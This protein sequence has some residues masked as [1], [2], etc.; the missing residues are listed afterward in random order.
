MTDPP[1]SH[2]PT[3]AL[4]PR[5]LRRGLEIFAVISIAGGAGA[6]LYGNNFHAF[7]TAL[8]GLHWWWLI[9]GLGLASLDWFGA[10][11]RL[12]VVGRHV[13]PGVRWLG[14]V[15]SMVMTAWGAS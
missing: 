7:I 10:G 4:T 2:A 1:D 15:I 12:W 5:L 11:T 8:L 6:L 9:V 3:L 14:I 13:N